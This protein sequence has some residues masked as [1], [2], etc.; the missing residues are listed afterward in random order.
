MVRN[1]FWLKPSPGV[2]KCNTDASIIE[3]QRLTGI[4]ICFRDEHGAFIRARTDVFSPS[5]L[6]PEGEALGLLQAL[7]WAS[8]MGI[9]ACIF[10]IDCKTV[11]DNIHSSKKDYPEFGVLISGCKSILATRS[12]FKIDF[13]RRQANVVAHSLAMVAT[14]LAGP[15]VFEFIPYCITDIIDNEMK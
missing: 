14:S 5:L 12:N 1:P 9:G 10:E 2:L 11:V 15:Q 8:E 7:R 3:Q 13:I 6:V 4:C